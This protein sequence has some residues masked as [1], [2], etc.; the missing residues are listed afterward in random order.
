[1]PDVLAV[2]VARACWE[3]KACSAGG[4][5]RG[6]GSGSRSEAEAGS[7]VGASGSEARTRSAAQAGP[8]PSRERG[9]VGAS[10]SSRERLA[11]VDALPCQ[12]FWLTC[13]RRAAGQV[14]A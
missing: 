11:F 5:D 12:H 1:V 6:P 14:T 4:I 2:E 9:V 13:N 3:R 8:V 7:G 10:I